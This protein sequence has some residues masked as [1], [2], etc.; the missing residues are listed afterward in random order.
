M[1]DRACGKT[2]IVRLKEGWVG[3]RDL[4]VLCECKRG[5]GMLRVKA[6]VK[7]RI[8]CAFHR[9]SHESS[10]LIAPSDTN[11]LSA[12]LPVS[13]MPGHHKTCLNQRLA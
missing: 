12:C 5:H 2:E 11:L 13:Q 6:E 7:C 9:K 1:K 8:L 3:G 10:V 4:G